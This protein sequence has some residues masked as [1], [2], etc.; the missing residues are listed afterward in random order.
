MTQEQDELDAYFWKR[1]KVI[2]IV[3]PL[4]TLAGLLIGPYR[5]NRYDSV[6][7]HSDKTAAV[8]TGKR[9][10]AAWHRQSEQYLV[11]YD[12]SIEDEKFTTTEDIGHRECFDTMTVG[13]QI[14]IYYNR[15]HPEQSYTECRLNHL[16]SK[17]F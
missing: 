13:Q 8:V 14:Y 7:Y 4:V 16:I 9:E 11:T 2:V 5:E 6:R 3:L 1:T 10:N 15:D 12:Y 17:K